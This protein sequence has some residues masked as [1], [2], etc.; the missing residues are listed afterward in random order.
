MTVR[1]AALLVLA[2]ALLAATAPD[3]PSPEDAASDLA[4]ARERLRSIEQELDQLA[5]AYDTAVA[6]LARL[7]GEA[8]ES[9]ATVE[10]A[11]QDHAE[12]Q[13]LARSMIRYRYMEPVGELW[14]IDA[15]RTAP[16]APAALHRTALLDH[17]PT[18]M[19]E[20]LA[21]AERTRELLL[22]TQQQHRT[23][24]AGAANARD[25]L[26]RLHDEMG[27]R[28]ALAEDQ[29]AAAGAALAEA[30]QREAAAAAREAA[31]AAAAGA[32]PQLVAGGGG[33]TPPPVMAC[34]LGLP[35]GFSPSWGAPRSG[36]RSHQGVD[37]FAARGMPVMAAAEGTV[38]VGS[39]RLG[40]LTVNL[41]DVAGNRY[42]Y[43]HLDNVVVNDGQQ[44]SA[45]QVVGGAGTSGNAR[46]TP[47]H[48]HWQ[49]HPGGGRPVDPFPIAA[50]LCRA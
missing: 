8:G 40:G 30:R 10:Q 37:M 28:L 22:D 36:G 24:L 2:L 18:V 43:A 23:V 11:H 16:S 7:D 4:D 12:A 13:A 44:V 29:L 3:G 27:V 50:T 9:D 14:V 46:G 33:W 19:A 15:W 26:D 21:R 20:L 35:N 32:G 42:Y 47:P 1:T 49:V 17:L 6:H 34:P 31:L 38:Q 48:L 5:S 45:G 25:D 39:N 41:Y